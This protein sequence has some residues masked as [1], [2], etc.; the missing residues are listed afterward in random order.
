MTSYAISGSFSGTGALSG[1]LDKIKG[2]GGSF[3]GTGTLTLDTNQ[4]FFKRAIVHNFDLSPANLGLNDG[5]VLILRSQ[6]WW[7][8]AYTYRRVLQI[9][10]NP[11]GFEIDHPLFSILSKQL[12]RQNKVRLDVA[13]IEVLRLVSF[14]P[15]T[16]QMVPKKV[17]L[18]DETIKVSWP[19]D[20]EIEKE[21]LVKDLYYIYYGNPELVNYPE[22]LDEYIPE[23]FDYPV[24][25]EY[26][27]GRLTY[28]RPGEHWEENLAKQDGGKATLEFYGSQ[29]RIVATIGPSY[30]IAEVQ[31]D[32]EEWIQV[33]LYSPIETPDTI[34]FTETGLALG[35]HF[36][37]YRRSGFKAASAT[38]YIINLQK[39]EYLRHNVVANVSEE[40]DETLMWSSAI[41]GVVG[42][43]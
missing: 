11:E 42:S 3:A 10:P 34:V 37:R 21:T 19:N 1:T 36:I 30:G 22:Q 16:W 6:V 12:I 20:V 13:D 26:S 24:V 25:L 40:A 38:D 14:L 43:K 7:D 33:D 9:Q 31:I 15:E 8:K 28:T 32:D 23:D 35:S 29:I 17:E 39:I 27:D 18:L 41:G 4:I 2:I 5:L